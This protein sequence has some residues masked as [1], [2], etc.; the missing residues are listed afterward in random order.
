MVDALDVVG[1]HDE[2]GELLEGLATSIADDSSFGGIGTGRDWRMW[3][4]TP[5]GYEGQLVEGFSVL[6]SALRRHGAGVHR[7]GS[8]L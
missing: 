2:A 4:G 8:H 3:D 6:T 5:S 1:M 7:T